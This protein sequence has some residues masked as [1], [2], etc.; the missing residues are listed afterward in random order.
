VLEDACRLRVPGGGRR[1]VRCP[2]SLAL[3]DR[4]TPRRH[5]LP[6]PPY[7]EARTGGSA[8]CVPVP[9]RRSA[10]SSCP[11]GPTFGR[12]E[13]PNPAVLLPPEAEAAGPT[14]RSAPSGLKK[15]KST[16]ASKKPK[17]KK[18][19]TTETQKKEKKIKEKKNKKR[20]K[21]KQNPKRKKKQKE[22][23]KKRRGRRERKTAASG[24]DGERRAAPRAVGGPVVRRAGEGGNRS[25]PIC[26]PRASPSPRDLVCS[27]RHAA[28]FPTTSGPAFFACRYT[29]GLWCGRCGRIPD[30]AGLVR[31][32]RRGLGPART[33]F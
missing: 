12:H 10:P 19:N 3:R 22:K 13:V 16:K 11:V 8:R 28:L 33:T 6:S 25:T 17:K 20:G 24:G 21:E 18:K 1:R 29:S 9:G 32:G 2:T 4:G 27:S 31:A 14:G 30:P 5:A 26:G 23:K 7:D 15:K